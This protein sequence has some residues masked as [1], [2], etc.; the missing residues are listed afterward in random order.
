MFFTTEAQRH[1]EKVKGKSIEST[2]AAEGTEGENLLATDG[3]GWT[4]IRIGQAKACPTGLRM[5]VGLCYHLGYGG[6]VGLAYG[7]APWEELT[8]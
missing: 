6:G 5:G 8:F 1:G 2:E 7:A 3:H 4:R